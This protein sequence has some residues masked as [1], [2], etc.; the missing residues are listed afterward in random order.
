MKKYNIHIKILAACGMLLLTAACS[1]E[2]AAAPKDGNRIVQVLADNFNLTMMNTVVSRSNLRTDLNTPG[3]FT[4]FAPSDEAFVKSGYINVVAVLGASSGLITSL[5]AYHTVEGTYDLNKLPFLFNQEITSRGG[6]LFVTRWVKGQ[7][8]ILT[9]N[10]SRLLSSSITASNGRVQVIDRML[11]PYLHEN[12]GD[13][14][15]A[16]TALTLFWQAVQ[17]AGMTDQLKGKGPFTIYAP[18]NDAMIASGY[19]TLE[20]INAAPVAA[21]TALVKYH[22]VADRRFVNDYILTTATGKT[23]TTQGMSDHNSITVSLTPNPQQPG[24]FTGITLRGIGNTTDVKLVKQDIISGNGVLHITDQV[25]R[26]T[27]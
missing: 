4:L 7:D 14:I 16:E 25:L 19:A 20:A 26:I 27:Q 22:V 23:T 11:Q 18:N 2:E 8:T 15:A 24:A 1:K 17:R 21:I 10:G 3:P 13:A 12:I 6:K 9:I 5:G